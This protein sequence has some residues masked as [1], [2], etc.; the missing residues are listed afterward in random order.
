MESVSG[1]EFGFSVFTMLILTYIIYKYHIEF[2]NK[3]LPILPALLFALEPEYLSPDSIP[4]H[5]RIQGVGYGL[6][7]ITGKRGGALHS[8]TS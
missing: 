8:S 5:G 2:P 7:Q 3:I 4:P 1:G 6:A